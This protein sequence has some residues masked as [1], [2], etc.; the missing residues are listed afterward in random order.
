MKLKGLI[1][2]MV[3]AFGLTKGYAQEIPLP[4]HPRPD[5]ER[6]NWMNLNGEWQFTFDKE[7]G[8]RAV[9]GN[10]TAKLDKVINVPFGWGTPLSGVD[11]GGDKGYYARDIVVPETWKGQRIFLVIGASDYDTQIWLNGKL[12]KQHKGGY[13]PFEVELTK[14]ITNY[15]IPQHLAVVVD[16][17]PDNRRLYGKQ[18]YGDVRGIWQTVYL[19]GRGQNYIDYIHF[20]PDIDNSLVNVEVGLNKPIG[21][22]G[23]LRIHFNN[24]DGPDYTFKPTSKNASDTI[25]K[26]TVNL[27]NQHL[28]KL[29]DPYLYEVKVFLN[30]NTVQD[31]VSSYFGQRKVSI[32]KMPGTDYT[33]VALNNEPIYLQL[34]LDQSYNPQGY[35]TFPSDKFIQ[36][37]IEISKKLGLDGNRVH[38]KAEVPRKLYWADKLGLL[39]MQDVPNWWADDNT[40][41][42]ADW[43]QCMRDQVKRDFNHPSIFAW[44]DF[45]ETWGL[46]T[47]NK[48]DGHRYYLPKTQAWVDSMYH[49]N[50]SLDPT[51]LVEDMSACNHDH[52][53]SDLNSWHAYMPGNGW[54][55]MLDDACKN[56]YVGSSWNFIGGHKQTG[57]PMFN[58][59][60]GNVWGYDNGATGDVDITWDYHQMMNAFRA[61][62]KCAGW[63]YTEHHDV[64]NEWNGYVRYDR[65][66]K[67]F[68]L[69]DFV[70]GM[71]M[72]DFH[73]PYYIS[74]R[75]PLIQDVHADS[76][77]VINRFL[78]VNDNVDKDNS[79]TVKSSLAGWDDLGNRISEQEIGN[80]EIV[81]Q[82]WFNNEI[83]PTKLKAPARNG[84]YVVRFVLKDVNGNILGRNF[85]LLRVRD[86]KTAADDANTRV[87]TF[88]P[89]SYVNSNWSQK[90]WTAMTGEKVNGTGHGF[91]EY[92]VN[93]PKNIKIKKVKEMALVF[94]ASAKRLNGKDREKANLE[95]NDYM[96]GKGTSERGGLPNSYPQTSMEK[97]P[98][99][100]NVYV[101]GTLCG[102]VRLPDDPADHR[103]VLSWQSQKDKRLDEAGS[104]GYMET[105]NI[106][107]SCLKNGKNAVVKFEV[108][109]N[110]DGGV[111]LYGENAGHYPLN[112]T[113][114]FRF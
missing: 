17:T 22:N 75:C 33:Y 9:R 65:S 23:T 73:S 35:Y 11:N 62:P 47:S 26:F 55:S 89:D 108:P 70:P 3:L 42:R 21:K 103:G 104:Y 91:F 81:I 71:T 72:R 74:P 76:V 45:N 85:T 100:L 102:T 16:D 25:F 28:W 98:S 90:T 40:L 36:N 57:A 39:I 13:T 7:N 27:Q 101:N 66:P 24:N 68:G 63:L 94:E 87:L 29:S 67:E 83:V 99:I 43:E 6:V 95:D 61:H 14:H 112:P 69:D 52:V 88:A 53:E 86:G 15:G 113:I 38:I 58:S 10:T 78:S 92:V 106:P 5:F 49:L 77:I 50:K 20:L 44:V 82:P 110:S 107:V 31:V 97:F 93:I 64:T 109:S 114:L 41:G 8:Q 111:A 37:E 79:V 96:L 84:L 54:E 56:T 59:E 1:F 105:I 46:F 4:E 12:L 48:E 34:T 80:D 2:T 30:N 51:R 60:C 19:E 18:G 32:V